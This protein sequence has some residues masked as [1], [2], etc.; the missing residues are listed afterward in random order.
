M[1]E[2]RKNISETCEAMFLK[3]ADFLTIQIPEMKSSIFCTWNRPILFYPILTFYDSNR[4]APKQI[5]SDFA[6]VA[7]YFGNFFQINRLYRVAF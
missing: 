1:Y 2:R 5:F 3:T 7:D 6:K 4:C